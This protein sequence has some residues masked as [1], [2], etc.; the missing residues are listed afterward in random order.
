MRINHIL[1]SI[2][3]FACP[4]SVM[5]M[6]SVVAKKEKKP[7]CIIET[8][9]NDKMSKNFIM[10]K[11]EQISFITYVTYTN[12]FHSKILSIDHIET[13]FAWRR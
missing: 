1:M 7:N 3:L 8:I 10:Y 12:K 4:M 6:E 9:K 11:G 5:S 2:M 13:E